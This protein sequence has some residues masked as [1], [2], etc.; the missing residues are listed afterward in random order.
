MP[1]T[2]KTIS[3]SRLKAHMLRVFREIEASGEEIIVTDHRRPVIRISPLRKK[4]SSDEIF[5]SYRG[6]VRYSGDLLEPTS[7]EWPQL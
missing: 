3:K 5:A 2:M 1:N 6:N 7:D 4:R